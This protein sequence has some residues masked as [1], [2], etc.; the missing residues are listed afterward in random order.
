MNERGLQRDVNS[1]KERIRQ[2]WPNIPSVFLRRNGPIRVQAARL[3]RFLDYTSL[4]HR[5]PVGR[6]S[7]NDDLVA[8]AAICT[9]HNKHKRRIL[10]TLAVF[11]PAISAIKRLDTYVLGATTTEIGS[12]APYF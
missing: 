12:F 8:E 7:T 3:L 2:I 4:V 5:H 6:L 1:S 10:M 11:E 9:T